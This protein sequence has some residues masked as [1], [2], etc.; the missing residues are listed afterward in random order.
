MLILCFY[1]IFQINVHSNEKAYSVET[2]DKWFIGVQHLAPDQLDKTKDPVILTHAIGTNTGLYTIKGDNS[3]PSLLNQSGYDVWLINFRGRQG[4]KIPKGIG[5]HEKDSHSMDPLIKYD[6]DTAIT[7]VLEQTGKKKVIYIGHSMGGFIGLARLGHYEEKRIAKFIS[8]AGPV[9]F[10]ILSYEIYLLASRLG[11]LVFGVGFS[12]LPLY[13]LGKMAAILDY[14]PISIKTVLHMIDKTLCLPGQMSLL[15]PDKLKSLT[16]ALSND[17]K[18]MWYQFMH[19]LRDHGPDIYS[20]DRSINYRESLHKIRVPSLL[21]APKKDILASPEVMRYIYDNLG[22]KDKTLFILSKANG[23]LHDYGH[24]DFMYAQNAHK[25]I[26][27]LI[28]NWL[29]APKK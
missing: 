24:T 23:M 19:A 21:I 6:V 15:A 10:A 3:L 13:N 22:S 8:L 29:K 14:L 11:P 17:P 12:Y 1:L 7:H 20:V 27:P 16:K 25:D 26:F 2:T 4:V 28:I 9:I 5:W 18:T